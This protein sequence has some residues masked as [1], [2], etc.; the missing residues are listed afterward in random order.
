M[1]DLLFP[2]RIDIWSGGRHRAPLAP[3]QAA[4][5]QKD[6]GYNTTKNSIDIHMHL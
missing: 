3:H 4:S 5:R 6:A 2:N 1:S